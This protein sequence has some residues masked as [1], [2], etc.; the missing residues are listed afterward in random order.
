M[1]FKNKKVIFFD[2]DGT[3]VDSI[4]DLSNSINYMLNT[5]NRKQFKQET[6]NLWVGNGG[7]TLVKRALSG[8]VNIDKNLNQELFNKAL[9]I[10]FD[11]Y[12]SNLGVHTTVYPDVKTTLI[13]LRNMGYKLAI[14]TNKPV[15]F[16]GPM[17]KNL[18]IDNLFD[19][20]LGGDSLEKR[21]PDAMPLLYLCNYFK[22]DKN[23][24]VMIGDSNNDIL[25][26]QSAKIDNIGVSYGYNYDEDIS[27]YNPTIVVHKFKDILPILGYKDAN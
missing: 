14:I 26:A 25:A 10:F 19:T 15:A 9:N 7:P 11:H 12:S 20:F 21:K 5:L 6:I 22:I 4:Q 18:D 2:M 8:S 1:E 3:L 13:K 27:V 16:V 23:E 24:A 17:L